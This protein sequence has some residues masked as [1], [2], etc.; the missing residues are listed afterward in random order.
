MTP[1]DQAQENAQIFC[2]NLI[3][4]QLIGLAATELDRLKTEDAAANVVEIS[5]LNRFIE[6]A[7]TMVPGVNA[8]VIPS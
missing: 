4:M 8:E 7:V 3:Q 2:E 1:F 5:R 6:V